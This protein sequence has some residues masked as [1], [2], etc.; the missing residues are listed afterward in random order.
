[1]DAGKVKGVIVAFLSILPQW[2]VNGVALGSIYALI[3]LGFVT[4]A[5]VTNVI[6]LAQGEFLMLGALL[7]VTLGHMLPLPLAG[8]LAVLLTA[9]LGAAVYRLA[10]WPARRASSVTLIVITIG[11]SV[12]LR[13]GALLLWGVDPYPLPPFSA[14]PPIALA[15]IVMTRQ[16]LWIIGITL[17]AVLL[18]WLFFNRTMIGRGLR[19]CALN[20]IAARLM[21]VP[22]ARMSM[23]AFALGAGLAALGGIVIT[24]V[25]YASYDM[26][27]LL[28]LKG[29]V[30][31]I[32][33]GLTNP[34]GAILGGLLLGALEA[35]GGGINSAYKDVVAFVIL[36]AVLLFRRMRQP[37][38]PAFSQE[39]L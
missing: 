35:V 1:V 23:L 6:N 26:G 4:I 24:P 37:Y 9:A 29:F 13:G 34:L 39:A 30:A 17:L 33:G 36:I 10:L 5:N 28:G 20:P 22:L 19:A 31:A 3:A 15:S 12:V 25:Q 16:A 11:V 14:G 21:G 38:S 27:L 32:M 8:L 18:L 2:L 7:A